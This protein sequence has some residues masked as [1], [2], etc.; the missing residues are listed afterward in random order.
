MCFNKS[1]SIV[2]YVAG[3]LLSLV[4]ITYGDKIDKHIGLF[5]LVFVQMQLAEYFM[6]KDQKCTYINHYASIYGH[7]TLLLQPISVILFGI[8]LNTFAYPK[9]YLYILLFIIILPLLHKIYLYANNTKK[10]C[11]K[12]EDSGHLEWVFVDGNTE[13]WSNFYFM[14]YFIFLSVPWLL[15]NDKFRGLLFFLLIILS[16]AYQRYNFPQWESKWCFYA[17]QTPLIFLIILILRNMKIVKYI[18]NF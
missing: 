3:T 14:L 9:K 10:L 13:D 8:I 18:K 11:T 17:V 16:Y 15:L 4:L 1:S 12:K 6:W 5:S 7:I 2:S